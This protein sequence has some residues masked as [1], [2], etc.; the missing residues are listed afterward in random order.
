MSGL[1]PAELTAL[2]TEIAG[3]WLMT[4]E[5]VLAPT[6]TLQDNAV[7]HMVLP[8]TNGKERARQMVSGDTITGNWYLQSVASRRSKLASVG[9]ITSSLL[10]KPLRNGQAPSAK[11]AGPFLVLNFQDLPKAIGNIK[12]FGFRLD[13][14]NWIIAA[15]ELGA[16]RHIQLLDHANLRERL[17]VRMPDSSR[18][19]WVRVR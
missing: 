6:I 11:D 9:S 5:N 19:T 8:A 7:M 17:S 1:N 15:D 2:R 3:T 14:I 4:S 16:G 18:Q 13:I 12:M 10:Q